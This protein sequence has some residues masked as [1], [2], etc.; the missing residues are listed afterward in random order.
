MKKSEANTQLE[1]LFTF[2]MK[3]ETVTEIRQI[4]AKQMGKN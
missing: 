1:E 3:P 2:S 4:I